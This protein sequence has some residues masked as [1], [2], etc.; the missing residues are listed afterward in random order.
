MKLYPFAS[1]QQFVIYEKDEP[2][3]TNEKPL[4]DETHE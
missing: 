1:N 2:S 3:M 4:V